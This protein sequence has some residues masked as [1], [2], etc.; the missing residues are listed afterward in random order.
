MGTTLIIVVIIIIIT[1]IIMPTIEN[2]VEC[3][4]CVWEKTADE[5]LI[6]LFVITLGQPEERWSIFLKD[7]IFVL[8]QVGLVFDVSWQLITWLYSVLSGLQNRLQNYLANVSKL[9][10]I[11]LLW[12]ICWYLCSSLVEVADKKRANR[13]LV[14]LFSKLPI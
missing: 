3:F 12:V 1:A 5:F 11:A 6:D 7:G 9:P 14:C 4:S 8:A 2:Y 13:A 10:Y